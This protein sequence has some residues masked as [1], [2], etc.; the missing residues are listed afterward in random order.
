MMNLLVAMLLVIGPDINQER[1]SHDFITTKTESGYRVTFKCKVNCVDN[2]IVKFIVK[3]PIN[4]LHELA[5][6][7]REV[8]KPI[9]YKRTQV[10]DGN[11]N[12]SI[13]LPVCGYFICEIIGEHE[14]QLD[15]EAQRKLEPFSFVRFFY[16][17]TI[18]DRLERLESDLDF[19]NKYIEKIFKHVETID[20]NNTVKKTEESINLKSSFGHEA[21]RTFLPTTLNYMKRQADELY[22]LLFLLNSAKINPALLGGKSIEDTLEAFKPGAIHKRFLNQILI[23][24]SL[25]LL[26]QEVQNFHDTVVND[27]L[28]PKDVE[29]SLT[30]LKSISK[31]IQ[32]NQE[33]ANLAASQLIVEL[34]EQL[35]DLVLLFISKKSD[36]RISSTIQRPSWKRFCLS[37]REVLGTIKSKQMTG[38]VCRAIVFNNDDVII[39]KMDRLS[40]QIRKSIEIATDKIRDTKE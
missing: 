13:I 21:R 1:S 4:E 12:C 3:C 20:A 7:I 40:G 23:R 6:K 10:K 15:L 33:Y 36:R 29:N 9:V 24:E 11:I 35:D 37:P 2:T 18:N 28:V 8:P 5:S 39:D 32:G 14:E 38:D 22:T 17:G 31:R 27:Q 34:Y 26:L 16:C 19:V 25:L 30:I